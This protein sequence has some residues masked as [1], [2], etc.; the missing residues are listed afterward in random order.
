MTQYF[1]RVVSGIVVEIITLPED[2]TPAKAFHADIAATL[3]PATASITVGQSFADGAFGPPPAPPA[4]TTAQL[5]AYAAAKQSAIMDGGLTVNVAA[6]GQPS[7]TVE[8]TTT[9]AYLTLLN[10]AVQRSGLNPSAILNWEQRDGSVLSLNATQ[11]QALGLAVANWLQHIFDT[12]TQ[13]IAPAIAAGTIT[14][15]AQIDDPTQVNLPAW[16][17]NS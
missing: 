2:V 9:S 6:A 10:G 4:P 8:V 11:T 15:T 5:L 7:L 17:A 13:S 12:R 1:A 3:A 14:T 16:P